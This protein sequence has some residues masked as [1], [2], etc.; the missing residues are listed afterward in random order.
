MTEPL[1]YMLL[2]RLSRGLRSVASFL[3]SFGA[4]T[5]GGCD[6]LSGLEQLLGSFGS[7][8]R[9]LGLVAC[10]SGSKNR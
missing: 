2:G 6:L 9:Q 5:L 4:L 7:Q 10:L 3:G 8:C 1:T